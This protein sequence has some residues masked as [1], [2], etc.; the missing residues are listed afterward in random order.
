MQPTR[1]LTEGS[2]SVRMLQ[3]ALP[4]LYAS[5]L[6]A[7][8]ASVNSFWV[9]HYL[10]ESALTA[11]SNANTVLFLLIGAAFGIAMA[12]T[13]LVGQSIGAGD[14]HEAKRVVG[15][16][17]TFFFIVS[18]GVAAIG[19]ILCRPLLIAMQT[20]ADA[21]PLAIPYMRVFFFALP[22]FYTYA[23]VIGVLRGAGDAQTPFYFLLLA[24]GLDIA[25]N[26]LFM[27]GVGPVPK[28]GIAGS[29]AA[30]FV[31]QATS[32]AALIRYLYRRHH[33]LCLRPEELKLL[34]VDR[35]ITATLLKMGIPMGAQPLVF[36][37]SGVLMIALVNRFGVE[38]TAAFGAALQVWNYLAMPAYAIN[39]VASSMAAQNV[40]ACKWD[41]VQ[42]IARAGVVYSLLLTGAGVLV[43]EVLSPCAFG[44][45]LP[46]DSQA[47]PIAA[48]LDRIVV[49][50]FLFQAAAMALFGVV[51]AVG[52]VVAPVVILAVSLLVVRFPL[53]EVL[54]AY[55]HEDAIWWSFPTSSA[56]AA[57]LAALYYKHG[58]WRGAHML[59][60]LKLR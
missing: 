37:L 8:N 47:L 12:A 3:L 26:P 34:R 27:F 52:E 49:G 18:V 19:L 11:V 25:L 13:I 33:M 42:S 15:T 17:A 21:L 32:L 38:T 7:L 44:L 41:R 23:F 14:L 16:G 54:L 56:L 1:S 60:H 39:M 53:A 58:R 22:C 35:S 5:I 45:F 55:Y 46:A 36:S 29:A 20:P 50:S 30:S 10:G 4:T 48:H 24:I 57:V 59:A 43:I 51:V 31:A 2:I 28:L 40:G 6:Q 9:G